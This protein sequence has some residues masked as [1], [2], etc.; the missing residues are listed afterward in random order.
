MSKIIGKIASINGVFYVK[1]ANGDLNETLKGSN[2]YEGDIIVGDSSN[3]NIDSLIVSMADG[4]EDVI[5]MSNHSQLFDSSLVSQEY[6]KH[7][8]VTEKET[9]ISIKKDLYNDFNEYEIDTASGVESISSFR[10]VKAIFVEANNGSVDI[11]V[12]V[13]ESEQDIQEKTDNGNKVDDTVVQVYNNNKSNFIAENVNDAPAIVTITE[14]NHGPIATDDITQIETVYSDDFNDADLDGWSEINFDG[15]YP[16]NWDVSNGSISEKSDC[17]RG[18]ISHDMG[19]NSTMTDYKIIVD[20][21]ANSGDTHNNYVGITFGYEDS[22]NYYTVEWVNYSTNYSSYSD[23]QNFNLVK[24]EDGVETILDTIYHI[25]IGSKFNLSVSV[26]S[27]D[28]ITVAVNGDNK[29]SSSVEHPQIETIGLNTFDNDNGIGYDNIVVQNTNA[30]IRNSTDEDSSIIIDVLANDK[31]VDGDALIVKEI[32]GQDVSGGKTVN[33]IS[34]DGNDIVLGT[35]R[36]VEGKVEFT[37]SEILQEM[38]YG[39]NQDVS[40]EYTVSDG[41]TSDTGS[42]TINVT[43][44]ND[45]NTVIDTVGDAKSSAGNDEIIFDAND[46]LID[47]GEGLDT[48]VMQG[49]TNIDFSGLSNK[50]LNIETIYLSAGEQNITSLSVY[51]VLTMT[52]NDN[53]LRIDGDTSDSINLDVLGADAQWKLGDFKTDA[54]TGA[55]YQEVTSGEGDST[56][57]LEI[58]TDI[59]LII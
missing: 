23:Y 17:A 25:D 27:K 2:I 57:T 21:D 47:G 9:I 32:Q 4:Y 12:E 43:G 51:D 8:T 45:R 5:V 19:D 44:A 30:T 40:F 33:V 13:T 1:Q 10:G 6:D 22:S 7:D 54:E 35:A 37:P 56:V 34:T 55:I 31:D 59:E 48:L 50:I 52:D 3:K 28:G 15:R 11:N 42:V 41:T 49:D 26:S 14:T 24:V 18:I 39:E 20:V 38:N 53:S 58:S 29:L 46:T 16:A 36:V